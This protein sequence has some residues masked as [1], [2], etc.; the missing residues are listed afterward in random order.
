MSVGDR[1]KELRLQLRLTQSDL[2]KK[3]GLSYIQI[4]RYEKQKSKPSAEV[5]QKLADALNTSADYLMNGDSGQIA[6]TKIT[7]RDLLELFQA[8]NVLDDQDKN[9]VKTFLDALITKRK[10]QSLA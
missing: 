6:S 3:V 1:I 2:A 4:G 9:M 8:V 7:D 5:L 10:V